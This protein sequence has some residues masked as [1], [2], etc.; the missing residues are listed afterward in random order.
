M[1]DDKTYLSDICHVSGVLSVLFPKINDLVIFMSVNGSDLTSGG[2]LFVC[3][4]VNVSLMFV[5][6]FR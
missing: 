5:M 4:S 1:I 3:G 6:C 2:D